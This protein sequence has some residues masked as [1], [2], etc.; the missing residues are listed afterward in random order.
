M[1]ALALALFGEYSYVATR[2]RNPSAY[3]QGTGQENNDLYSA[4]LPL[5]ALTN[6]DVNFDLDPCARTGAIKDVTEEVAKV[7]TLVLGTVFGRF[8]HAGCPDEGNI[9][10]KFHLADEK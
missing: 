7:A 5:V 6:P 1:L 9:S 3:Q 4:P 2:T 10:S 8:V